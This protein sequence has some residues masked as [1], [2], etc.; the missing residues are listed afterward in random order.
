MTILLAVIHL[1]NN[2]KSLVC[3]SIE[4]L[5]SRYPKPENI[6]LIDYNVKYLIEEVFNYCYMDYSMFSSYKCQKYFDFMCESIKTS[7]NY[8]TY[9]QQFYFICKILLEYY[10]KNYSD[11]TGRYTE[12]I[13][14]GFHC[15]L[16]FL[17]TT[18][19]DLIDDS[20][21]SSVKNMFRVLFNELNNN[22]CLIYNP[23]YQVIRM[24]GLELSDDAEQW[25]C[26]TK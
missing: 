7:D 10:K 3:E 12:I 25:W 16:R 14:E 19:S 5:M 18:A 13:L 24:Q 2:S 15:D 6:E 8:N 20:S 21:I 1:P 22:I 17:L 11:I 23:S 4:H 9:E 26:R